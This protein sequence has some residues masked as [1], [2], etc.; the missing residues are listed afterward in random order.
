MI[1]KDVHVKIYSCHSPLFTME[2]LRSLPRFVHPQSLVIV[3]GEMSYLFRGDQIEVANNIFTQLSCIFE[4]LQH[5]ERKCGNITNILES[6]GK[7]IFFILQTLISPSKKIGI[8]CISC[9]ICKSLTQFKKSLGIWSS[10]DVRKLMYIITPQILP[11]HILDIGE[12]QYRIEP[13]SINIINET[14][15]TYI[16]ILDKLSVKERSDVFDFAKRIKA[17]EWKTL[18]SPISLLLFEIVEQR[19]NLAREL[20]APERLIPITVYHSVGLANLFPILLDDGVSEIFIDKEFS[21]AYLDHRD[22]GRCSTAVYVK[23]MDLM[24]LLTFARMASGKVIDYMSPSLRSSIKT[25]EFYVRVSADAPPLAMGGTSVAVRKFFSNPISLNELI[26]N[27]T[28]TEEA[29]V[30][31]EKKIQDRKN[32]SI[33]GESGSGKTTLAVALDLLTPSMWRKISVESDVAENV[34]QMDFGKHQIRLLASTA[35]KSDQEK[36]TF[37][38]NSLLHKSPDYVFFGEVLSREDSESLF[39]IF[40]AGLKCIHTIHAE[41]GESLL[42]RWVFQH[43]IPPPS[44]RDLDTLVELRKVGKEGCITRKVYRISEL[45]KDS[46]RDGIPRLINIFYWDPALGELKMSCPSENF[47]GIEKQGSENPLTA[48]INGGGSEAA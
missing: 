10:Y 5:C 18:K 23:K 35:S 19:K 26:S 13:F 20:G 46:L 21:Y 45:A 15:P 27:E 44:L 41:S 34:T 17:L 29:A 1:L 8:R 6:I 25:D 48:Q 12:S 9:Q 30:F 16:P 22:Y 39:Q 31:L 33:Y 43:K 36:R 28:L 32:I 7:P 4:Y 40:S 11:P 24:H 3:R 42:R 37:I 38:L 14:Y 47:G 2:M